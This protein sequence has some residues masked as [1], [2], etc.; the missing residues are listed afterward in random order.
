MITQQKWHFSS[1]FTN[2][3]VAPQDDVGKAVEQHIQHMIKAK[4]GYILLNQFCF[5]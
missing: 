4:L 5:W 3:F 2:N 1:N